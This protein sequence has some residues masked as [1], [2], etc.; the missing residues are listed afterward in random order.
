LLAVKFRIRHSKIALGTLAL[1][2]L[3][4][5]SP[6]A[7]QVSIPLDR[8]VSALAVLASEQDSAW[9]A[10]NPDSSGWRLRWRL[11]ATTTGMVRIYVFAAPDSLTPA[12]ISKLGNGSQPLNLSNFPGIPPPV[13]LSDSDTSWQIPVSFLD[14]RQGKNMRTDV[15]YTFEVWVQYSSG[16][17]GRTPLYDLFF[18]DEN[19]P[20]IPAL[21]DSEGQTSAVLRFS[22]PHDQTNR[23]DTLFDGPLRTVKAL[24]WPGAATDSA[25][26]VSSVQVSVDSLKNTS[27]D[28]FRLVLSPLKYWTQYSYGLQLVDTA[29]NVRNSDT[30][31]FT[32]LDSL[33]PAAPMGLTSYPLR[34]DSVGF[35]WIAA[36]DTLQSDSASRRAFPNYHIQK[37]VVRLNG[38]RVD[39]VS[40]S[41]SDSSV[42]PFFR[43]NID[44]AIGRFQWTG[45]NWTWYWRSFRPG[46]SYTMDLI[47][48][49][50]SGNVAS[51]IPS[52]VVTSPAVA[53]V[54]CDS[55]WVAVL[56]TGSGLSNY[57]IEEHEHLSGSRIATRV[58]WAQ[59]VQT[60]SQA[61]AE[62]CSEAQWVH[63][64]ETFPDNTGDTA[65]YGAVD[66]GNDT[67]SWLE[68][69]CQL[70]TGDSVAML[71]PTNSDP[72]CVSGW[73]VYDMPGRVSEWTRDV[74]LTVPDDTAS[75]L[76][77]GTL[78][79]LG[80]SDLTGQSDLGTL[81]GGSSLILDQPGQTLASARCR[82]RNYP[83]SSAVDST[84]DSLGNV[85]RYPAPNP[86][87]ISSAWGFRCCKP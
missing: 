62:L 20:L 73:G 58:T 6:P 27:V 15:H 71:D 45:S 7:P 72:L 53:G 47:V 21:L 36:A 29:G 39:S 30:Y 14:G 49:D 11:P 28:S 25:G 74:Y 83:A 3:F 32:T 67:L 84:T 35:S 31:Q 23:F 55:G 18:G 48:Y 75:Q 60:C 70:N 42:V 61:G 24:W 57:C 54:A 69:H 68:T 44:T 8:Q 78:A 64:C 77:P 50:A 80:N 46:K 40:W 9:L 22:R 65:T 56:G 5:C 37:Y 1:G 79:Y 19:A 86:Q 16:P 38:V 81:H 43:Q 63:A 85:S 59:A 66:V 51:T 52:T 10:R 2:V 26:H 4:S 41:A 76:E 33:P 82:E 17:T 12:Q 34:T 13:P 87:G